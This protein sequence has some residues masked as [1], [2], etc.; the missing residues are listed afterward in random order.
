M[1]GRCA[2]FGAGGVLP[3]APRDPAPGHLSREQPESRQD[4]VITG[5]SRLNKGLGLGKCG[6]GA[7][8]SCLSLLT[9]SLPPHV[10]TLASFN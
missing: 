4:K 5:M 3:I 1:L 7:E 9:C 2:S 10:M 6:V 8:G